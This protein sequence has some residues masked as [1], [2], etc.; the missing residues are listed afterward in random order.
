MSCRKRL[1]D[2]GHQARHKRDEQQRGSKTRTPGKSSRPVAGIHISCGDEIARASESQKAPNQ[3]AG[4][5]DVDAAKRRPERLRGSLVERASQNGGLAVGARELGT[6][7]AA[8]AL[9]PPSLAVRCSL[10]YKIVKGK[11]IGFDW[12]FLRHMN[13]AR[14]RRLFP[15]RFVKAD[16]SL[17]DAAKAVMDFPLGKTG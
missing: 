14:K 1:Q 17:R 5:R 3:R 4:A 10:C 12:C 9:N 16:R 13:R 2:D 6:V 11:E 7:E 15:D 8:V